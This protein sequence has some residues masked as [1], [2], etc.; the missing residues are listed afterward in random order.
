[1]E[2]KVEKKCRKFRAWTLK[3]KEPCGRMSRTNIIKK[4]ADESEKTV[5]I[6]NP[7]KRKT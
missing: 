3:F 7:Q 6:S 2:I 4:I 5:I 1:M